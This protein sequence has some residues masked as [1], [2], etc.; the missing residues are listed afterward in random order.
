MSAA[1]KELLSK[2]SARPMTMTIAD[3]SDGVSGQ[4][5]GRAYKSFEILDVQT[6]APSSEVNLPILDLQ[7][8][9]PCTFLLPQH[10]TTDLSIGGE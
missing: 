6:R 7:P 9:P 2:R 5:V 4:R 3:G 1:P 10:P 8:S